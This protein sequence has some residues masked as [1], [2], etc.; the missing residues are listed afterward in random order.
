[1]I[2][3]DLTIY[4]TSANLGAGDMNS[5]T[6]LRSSIAQGKAVENPFIALTFLKGTRS[7]DSESFTKVPCMRK[8]YA[9]TLLSSQTL[10]ESATPSHTGTQPS[11]VD[12]SEQ[13]APLANG[14]TAPKAP[15]SVES[16]LNSSQLGIVSSGA[17]SE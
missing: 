5:V 9:L 8:C 13:N 3:K 16:L 4:T 10:N 6:N 11:D 14:E 17:E 7:F 1:M 15:I 12:S 2:Q